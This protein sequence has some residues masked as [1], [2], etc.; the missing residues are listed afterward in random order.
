MTA[1]ARAVTAGAIPAGPHVRNACRRHLDDL[2]KGPARGLVWNVPNEREIAKAREKRVPVAAPVDHIVSYFRNVLRLAGGQFEGQPFELAPSQQFI[3]GSLHGWRR[4]D[5][6]RRFRRAYIEEGKG[7]GKS[8]L[9]AGL[10]MYGLTSDD[11]AR[12]EIYAAASKKDQAMVLFRDAVAM[13]QQSPDL[14]ARLVASGGN[15]V[16]NLTDPR[17]HSFFRPISSDDGQSGPRPH[18]A[19]L[20]EI[21][22]HRNGDMVETL[23]RGFKFRR[24]PLLVMITNSGTDRKSVCYNEHLHAVRVCAG[25]MLPD[26]LYTYVGDVIDDEAFG[27][28]CALDLGEDP[29]E[30]ESCWPKANPLLGSTVTMDYLRSVVR[31]AKKIPG[32]QNGV[33]RLHFCVWTDADS[34]WM[35]KEVL[36]AV[37]ADFDPEVDHAGRQVTSASDL[38]GSQ[39]LTANAYVVETGK[40]LITNPDGTVVNKPTY[41][42]WIEAWTPEDTMA[43]R[44][45][46]D[47]VPYEEWVKQGYL[48]AVPGRL[49]RLDFVAARLA[50]VQAVHGIRAHAY[51]RYA[52]GKLEAE[53]DALGLTF[54]QMEHP[55]GGVRKAKPNE[56]LVELAKLEGRPPPQGLWMPG[57]LK[58]LEEL[59]LEGRIRLLRNPV[60]FAACMGATIETDPMDNRWFSKRKATNRIDPL[61]ALAMAVGA[62]TSAAPPAQQPS[63][64]ETRGVLSI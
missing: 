36:D 60:L 53:L 61:V 43:E 30:D 50:E 2:V 25:T 62:A 11:E 34:A 27:Y 13:Y 29:L 42:A 35:S 63:V 9:A 49:I 18:F 59:F 46:R 12:A 17:T 44:S 3:V 41:D 14:F 52:Y 5:G 16:W 33:L 31:Q 57:S 58:A 28:V 4:L 39:D 23:E 54:P 15:P 19:L 6:T 20:D 8:P 37:M 45:R 38:S 56:K 7:N 26:E 22:E 55:Q 24:Q 51:D 1:Y 64:Y 40:K 21:H 32:K 48:I 47:Q 10:G